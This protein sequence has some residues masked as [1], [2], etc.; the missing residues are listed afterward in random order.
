LEHQRKEPGKTSRADSLLGGT[1]ERRDGRRHGAPGVGGRNRAG[2][3]GR[4]HVR[5]R[6]HAQTVDR[7]RDDRLGGVRDRLGLAGHGGT[8]GLRH[9][10]GAGAGG[11]VHG[12]GHGSV[13]PLVVAK[14]HICTRRGRGMCLV[15]DGL[16]VDLNWLGVRGDRAIGRDLD[17]ARR[18]RVGRQAHD[19]A[20]R[21]KVKHKAGRSL[22]MGTGSTVGGGPAFLVDAGG[23]VGIGRG[24]QGHGPV[25]LVK[26]GRLAALF[27]HESQGAVGASD[28]LK[29]AL[30][31]GVGRRLDNKSNLVVLWG[32]V[33][34]SGH[35]AHGVCDRGPW[36]EAGH[37]L[38][39][40]GRHGN[41]VAVGL[42]DT[43]GHGV[44]DIVM[45]V[46]VLHVTV[47]HFTVHGNATGFRAVPHLG[48]DTG[49]GHEGKSESSEFHC[50]LIGFL[51]REEK[52]KRL[53]D[54]ADWG[55]LNANRG[56]CWLH[57][58]RPVLLL[59]GAGL[60]P[61]PRDAW[62]LLFRRSKRPRLGSIICT[63]CAAAQ[64]SHGGLH[65][66]AHGQRPQTGS[67]MSA[68]AR[69]VCCS[70]AQSKTRLADA[71]GSPVCLHLRK[72]V[73]CGRR[74]LLAHKLIFCT[75]PRLGSK[76][77]HRLQASGEEACRKNPQRPAQTLDLLMKHHITRSRA[78]N[79]LSAHS[80]SK[81]I[82][83]LARKPK[84]A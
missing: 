43:V 32:V 65:A 72:T 78:R 56:P 13:A 70:S 6:L 10:H 77:A 75:R 53:P 69:V 12:L 80:Q 38:H 18:R 84:M 73:S 24:L 76:R 47:L 3:H 58:T 55:A 11:R 27:D 21:V 62:V 42:A 48:H 51:L 50:E 23:S 54:S 79:P 26:V 57:G 14:A 46:T 9:S 35:G 40:R 20:V 17:V 59:F 22:G 5:A 81:H 49:N 67:G 29:G 4:R 41:R 83:G 34:G 16:L 33:W 37:G 25:L 39:V 36:V 60:T 7:V 19:F 30:D 31:F 82:V 63:Q 61:L 66:G 8:R 71:G 45:H 52:K 64:P 1:V 2:G 68:G 28:N 44:V 15:M 74:F